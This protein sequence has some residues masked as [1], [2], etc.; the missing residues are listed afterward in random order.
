VLDTIRRIETP[1]GV[2]LDL[3]PAGP[4]ARALALAQDQLVLWA[5]L[6][7]AMIPLAFLG[8][9]GMGLWMILL[10]LA[11]WLYPVLFEVLGS[12]QTLGKRVLRLRVLMADG[13][14]VTWEASL[15]RNLL[16]VVDALPGAYTV[17]LASTLFSRDFQR[18]GDLVAGTLVVHVPDIPRTMP[19]P[20]AP[21][22]ALPLALSL[23][24]Q[25]ALL[26]F[27]ERSSQLNPARAEELAAI[28][29][30]L[31][32]LRGEPGVAALQ[33]MARHIRGLT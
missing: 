8:P 4:V 31:T 11:Q 32:G 1:E 25:S 22:I 24:E 2:E 28:L 14:P 16:R 23:E 6:F 21:T 33:G 3:R 26:A 17:G 7:V 15:L 13:L 5:G 27:G 29:E 10:F 30:G 12:G 18:V 9:V 20:M 19:I